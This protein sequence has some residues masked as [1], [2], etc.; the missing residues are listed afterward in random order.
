MR[1]DVRIV[2]APDKFKDTLTAPQVARAIAA[3]VVASA[4]S[5]SVTVRPLADG[6]EGSLYALLGG[7]G[8]D[9]QPVP[10]RDALGRPLTAPVG[11]LAD[12]RAFVEA[13]ATIGLALLDEP[14]A[15]GSSSSGAGD[16]IV[17]AIEGSG[18][19][20]Q[21]VVGVGGTAS[22]DGGTGAATAAGWRFVDAA[23]H[24]LPPGGGSLIRLARIDG[25]RV[26]PKLRRARLVAAC[27]VSNP[28][29]GPRGSARVFAPQKGASPED[30]EVL[31]A[32]IERLAEI[33]RRDLGIDVAGIPRAGAGGGLA[34]GLHAFFGAELVAGFD[35]I[36]AATGVPGAIEAADLV[37]TGEGRIDASTVEGKV[38]AGVARLARQARVRCVAVAGEIDDDA[39]RLVNELGLARALSLTEL[40][41]PAR[42][43]EEAAARITEATAALVG[44]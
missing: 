14:D 1:G 28:L 32:G 8:G 3:G 39:D 17:H 38:V 43:R 12:G 40:F 41:G 9:V 16:A 44:G 19:D 33:V 31:E 2:V 6:G 26:S 36:A 15:L 7:I 24:D 4:P 22:T 11:Y 13:A 34:A 23:G 18:P 29:T 35:L 42:A 37:I 30:V 25:A 5:A 21:V 20:A 27:D 10:A